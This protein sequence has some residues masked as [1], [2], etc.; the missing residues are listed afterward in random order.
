MSKRIMNEVMTLAED[1]KLNIWYQDT[2]SIHINYEEVALLAKAFKIKYNRDLIGNDMSQ[3]HIDFDLE[4]ACGE[5]Y[6]N[7]AYYLAKKVYNGDLE[8]VDK[9]KDLINGDHIRLKSVPTSCVIHTAKKMEKNVMDLYK[10]LFGKNNK[11]KFDLTE[12]GHNCG[13]KYNSDLTVRSYEENEFTREI[14]F[15]PDIERIEIF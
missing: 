7:E 13:F 3:F 1:E 4:G 15:C 2:D 11:I 5:V 10:H 8:S 12:D 9:N 6:S 14:G